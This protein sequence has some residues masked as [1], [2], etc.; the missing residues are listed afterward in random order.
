[1]EGDETATW[2][3]IDIFPFVINPDSSVILA[4]GM[5]LQKPKVLLL[6]EKIECAAENAV[7]MNKSGEQI[8]Q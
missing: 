4:V 2:T 3:V 6:L 7:T 5:N 1:M 8:K